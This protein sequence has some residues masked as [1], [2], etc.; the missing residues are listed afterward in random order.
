MLTLTSLQEIHPCRLVFERKDDGFPSLGFQHPHQ[1]PIGIIHPDNSGLVITQFN[2]HGS[3]N[4]RVRGNLQCKY[5][6][7]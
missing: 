4:Y 3:V 1:L 2:R 7:R 5:L 6:L